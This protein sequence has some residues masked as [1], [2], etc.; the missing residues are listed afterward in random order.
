MWLWKNELSG[1]FG[2]TTVAIT[3]T[4]AAAATAIAAAAAT[5]TAVAATAAA[6]RRTLFAGTRF[7]DGQC[8]TLKL[9]PMIL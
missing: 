8:A 3:A 5:T 4:T 9:L 2:L 1:P 6:A 7:I